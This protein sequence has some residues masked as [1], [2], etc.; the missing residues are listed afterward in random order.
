MVKRNPD[1]E[2]FRVLI[3]FFIVVWHLIVHGLFHTLDQHSAFV[4]TGSIPALFNF[5][6]IEY[7][8]YVTAVAVNCFV[9]ISGYFL[10][11]SDFRWDKILIIWLQTFFYSFFI[12]LILQLAGIIELDFKELINRGMPIRINDY[13]FISKYIALLALSPFLAKLAC[14]LN[15]KEYRIGLLVLFCM[16]ISL[17]CF[18]YGRVYSGSDSLLWFVFLFF[19]A[20]YI[21]L[22]NP[23]MA[24]NHLLGRGF[25]GMCLI[26]LVALLI[27]KGFLYVWKKEPVSY[28]L[29]AYNGYTFFTSVLL[30]L[31]A[32]QHTFPHNFLFRNLVKIA[33]F[34]L[35][36]YL[37]HDNYYIRML[38]WEDWL[39][40]SRYLQSWTLL[41]IL[42]ITSLGIFFLCIFI[43]F[44]RSV[45]FQQFRLNTYFI[46]FVHL[47][48]VYFCKV[49]KIR[50]F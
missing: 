42:F 50:M 40:V 17:N 26:L 15:Q 44:L 48:G 3:M 46:R 14:I 21:R 38:L 4:E 41:P 25:L 32:K 45:C 36:V 24:Y 1:F 27:Q 5:V 11:K 22:Y 6:V 30:F 49:F 47:L 33:P 31:W 28:D 18:S 20:G 2:I 12:C 9:L 8:M 10:I 37:I 13:W 16:N 29:T 35:G 23:F 7:L 19:V 34:T 39:P 43:D